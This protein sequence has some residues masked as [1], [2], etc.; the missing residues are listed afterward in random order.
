MFMLVRKSDRVAKKFDDKESAFDQST[1]DALKSLSIDN[2]EE[3]DY[4]GKGT[5]AF[6]RVYEVYEG[7]L[8]VII[9]ELEYVLHKG[10][11]IFIEKGMTFEMKGTFKMIAI[12]KVAI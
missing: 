1:L 12:N 5:A 10:D 2:F 11:S 9:N 6:N 4:Y 8:H 7:E 3:T